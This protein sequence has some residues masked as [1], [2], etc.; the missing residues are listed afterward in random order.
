M[1][2][3]TLGHFRIMSRLGSGG[4]GVVYRALDEKLQREIAIK[5]MEGESDRP[6]LDRRRIIDEARAASGLSHPNICT[7]YE[8]GEVAG[9][10]YIAMEYVPGQALSEMIPPGG[11]AAEAVILSLIHI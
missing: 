9:Q 4:M 10:A 8:T 3:Q 6:D 2:G 7:V 11:L 1:I 5:V